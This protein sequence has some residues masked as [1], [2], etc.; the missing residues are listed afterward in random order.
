MSISYSSILSKAWNITWKYKVLWI[1]GFLAA[2]GGSGWGSSSGGSYG[3]PNVES[4]VNISPDVERADIPQE[5]KSTYD[6]ISKIDL[7]TWISVAVIAVCCLALLG[8]AL[9]LLSII[10][11]GGLIGGI[12]AADTE[13]KIT[14]REAWAVGTRYFWRL[15]LVRLLE[16]AIGIGVAIVIVL[17][18]AFIG[19]LTCGIGFIP[20]VCGMFIIGI[21]IHIWFE[22]MNYSIVVE[23]NGVGEAIGRAWTVMRDN[24]GPIIV[25]YIILFAVSLGVGLATLILFAPAGVMI[26][27]SVLPL[28]TGLAGLN[29]ALLVIGIVLL[30]LFTIAAWMIKAVLTVW[31][32]AVMVLAYRE[33]IKA[34]PLL[35]S[36]AEQPQSVSGS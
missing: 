35:A 4:R 2:L 23:K 18:G 32:T 24:I 6:Q 36:T 31:E 28:I 11:R 34:S 30:V 19:I 20:L 14:F 33:F 29:V 5:W 16:I 21:V 12:L 7:N 13:G 3:S 26:F 27:L 17:P 8:L 10:G 25:L 22:F 15:F 9:W 1:F